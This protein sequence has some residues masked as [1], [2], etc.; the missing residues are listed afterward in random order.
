MHPLSVV[1]H[2]PHASTFIPAAERSSF[3]TDVEDE[4]LKMTDMYCGE[5][6]CGKYE[7]A[8]FPVSRLVCDPERFVSDADE[9][10][11]RVG[12]GAVYTRTHSGEKL[13]DVSEAERERII[14]AYY[15]PH[16]DR[17]TACVQA[18]LDRTGSCLII[19]G[20]SFPPLPLPYEPDQNPQ[21]PDFCIGTDPFHTPKS[22]EE[23]AAGFLR[24]RGFTAAVNAPFAGAMVP[25]R[26]YRRDA[27]VRS[28][29]IE[30]NRRLYMRGDGSKNAAFE[31]IR[32]T[33]RELT[34]HIVK[35]CRP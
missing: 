25:L 1:V 28:V 6:F 3:L 11:S 13:R 14:G 2:V 29:M 8:V 18:A 19:D 4:L 27:R 21:R 9:P 15:R 12:M 32:R 34:D 31:E 33:V 10:M 26:F 17:L 5:L 35:E 30:V 7:S 22:L 24:E 23:S 20:H 16:H